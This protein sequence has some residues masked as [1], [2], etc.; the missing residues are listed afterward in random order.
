MSI[1]TAFINLN[2]KMTKGAT[3]V[4]RDVKKDA[5]TRINKIGDSLEGFVDD[6]FGNTSVYS[7]IGNPNNPP[8]RILKDA[9][10]LEIKQVANIRSDIALNSSSPKARLYA[11]DMMLTSACRECEDGWDV[12]DVVYII[13]TVDR[14]GEGG[15]KNVLKNIWF[16]F[17]DCYAADNEVYDRMKKK[18]SVGVS[19]I[20]GEEWAETKELGR[21]NRVDPLGITYLRVRGMWGIQHPQKV[22]AYIINRSHDAFMLMKKERFLAFSLAERRNIPNNMIFDVKIK[23]PNNPAKKINAVLLQ[24]KL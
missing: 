3:P 11:N 5:G 19:S 2:D 15:E 21:L 16:V 14:K 13:G 20:A 24:K 6:L 10:A 9:E 8:D 22:F 1:L 4:V 23:S 7:Y 12:K 17:G 18:V